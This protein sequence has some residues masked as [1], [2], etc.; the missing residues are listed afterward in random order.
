LPRGVIF[1]TSKNTFALQRWDGLW[2]LSG[3]KDTI[4]GKCAFSF[5]SVY[6]GNFSLFQFT[7]WFFFACKGTILREGGLGNRGTSLGIKTLTGKYCA[8]RKE[9]MPNSI[10][11]NGRSLISF[12]YGRL[13]GSRAQMVF[14][15]NKN[16]RRNGRR[17]QTISRGTTNAALTHGA[18]D[19]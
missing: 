14:E 7:A 5:F 4:A 10:R 2:L 15:R 17:Q 6:S 18:R 8:K 13:R 16:T 1:N 3:C 12:L 11:Q 9:K 19:K